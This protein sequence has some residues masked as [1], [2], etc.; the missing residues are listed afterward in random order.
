[1][2][3]EFGGKWVTE[4]LNTRLGPYPAVCGIQREAI[5]FYKRINGK[6]LLSRFSAIRCYMSII[7]L[8]LVSTRLS[9]EL[10]IRKKIVKIR[11]RRGV[12]AQA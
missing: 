10:Q 12:V 11:D 9:G 8:I 4:C 7:Y 2:P 6:N 3:P 5:F 1:M